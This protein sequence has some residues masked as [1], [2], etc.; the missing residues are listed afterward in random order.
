[1]AD[2]RPFS[3]AEAAQGAATIQNVQKNALAM[4]AARD[5]QARLS[6]LMEAAAGGDQ[7]ALRSV[8]GID[9]EL[10]NQILN[11][12]SKMSEEQRENFK[13][14]IETKGRTLQAV[15]NAP[16][17]YK[18]Q[19][20]QM[21][22]EELV[23]TLGPDAVKGMPERFDPNWTQMNVDKALSASDLLNARG[24]AFAPTPAY[25][26][27]G[28]LVFMQGTNI[29]G[30]APTVIEG[31]RPIDKVDQAIKTAEGKAK[32]EAET[33]AEIE[34][35]KAAGKAAIEQSGKAIESLTAV[36]KN[37]TNIDEAIAAIDAG[38]KS[39]VIQSKFPS[40]TAASVE[41]DNIRSRMG[42]DV[43]S[44]TTFGAL[45]EGELKFALKSA[46]PDNMNEKDL[47]AWLIKKKDAQQK[48]A[49]ELENAAIYLGKPGNTPAGYLEFR[50]NQQEQAPAQ[51]TGTAAKSK[52]QIKV[53]N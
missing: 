7:G 12:T 51:A 48:L 50:R 6:P 42:L 35:A 36:R 37:M 29:P 32:V 5:K 44:G 33:G 15:L 53:K 39:G 30:K 38:A 22:K 17:V 16:D 31:L 34:G 46:V 2:F 23:S 47:K 40:I 10:G 3:L 28:N 8:T 41:L 20:W 49:Q 45:S 14:G 21:A 11:V 9:P 25:D 13:H 24:T 19:A 52:Y 4:A 18:D 43:I 26:K 1:M 27:D